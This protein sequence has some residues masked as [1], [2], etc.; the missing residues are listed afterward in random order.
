MGLLSPGFDLVAALHVRGC[1][2]CEAEVRRLE[3]V[4][5]KKWG[6]N[7]VPN[8]QAYFDWLLANGT[9]KEKASA[10]D[11]LDN[12][13]LDDINKFDSAMVIKAAK[14]WKPK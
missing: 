3:S 1:A 9:V 7:L 8:Y 11:V 2:A 10:S 12:S 13:L 14:E 4:G 6:E 5:A